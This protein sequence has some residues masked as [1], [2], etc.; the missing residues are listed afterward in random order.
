MKMT[1]PPAEPSASL[2]QVTGAF[3]SPAPLLLTHG[4]SG[5]DHIETF[6]R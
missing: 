2:K 4:K 5:R 6:D 1:S 3:D